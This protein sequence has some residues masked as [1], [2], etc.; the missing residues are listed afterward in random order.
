MNPSLS[1]YSLVDSQLIELIGWVLL[2]SLWQVLLVAVI[3]R[4]S[5][6]CKSAQARYWWGVSCL[7]LI[8][9]LPVATLYFVAQLETEVAAL[10]TTKE[11][12]AP[13]TNSEVDLFQEPRAQAPSRSTNPNA[14]N[15]TPPATIP[16]DRLPAE[17]NP[18]ADHSSVDSASAPNIE[19][20]AVPSAQTSLINWTRRWSPL[21]VLG[22]L[23]GVIVLSFRPIMGWRF[24][25]KLRSTGLSP[26]PNQ[27]TE[28][29][30]RLATQLKVHRSVQV[31]QSAIAQVPM[32]VG[33]FK[34]VILV[35]ASAL[36][37]LTVTE[38][39]SILR[40][41]LAHVRRHDA[42]V[43]FLQT[44][45]ETVLFFHPC[46]WWISRRVRIEREN[47][48][49]DL[50]ASDPAQAI[51]LAKALLRLEEN[52]HQKVGALAASDG[53]LKTRVYRLTG[54]GSPRSSRRNRTGVVA[55]LTTFALV[56]VIF[57][58]F[59]AT[60][61]TNSPESQP[62]SEPVNT[63]DESAARR[64]ELVEFR[65]LEDL[66]RIDTETQRLKFMGDRY[67]VD[68]EWLELIGERFPDLWELDLGECRSLAS[69][70][71]KPLPKLSK[72][73]ALR[74]KFAEKLRPEAAGYISQLQNLEILDISYA[75]RMIGDEA[76][77]SL[78]KLQNLHTLIAMQHANGGIS[79][80]SVSAMQTMGKLRHVY[81]TRQN[82]ITQVP[83][84]QESQFKIYEVGDHPWADFYSR[85]IV[86]VEQ[87]QAGL[88]MEVSIP[89]RQWTRDSVE[90][91][92]LDVEVRVVDQST[93]E[94][95]ELDRVPMIHS[96]T[97]F[98]LDID[99][100]VY[101]Y[102]AYS[103][104][105]TH[106]M[107]P[108]RI[109]IPLDESMWRTQGDPSIQISR[110]NNYQTLRL[111]PGMHTLKVIFK[112]LGETAT[113]T[114]DPLQFEIL[115]ASPTDKDSFIARDYGPTDRRWAV[116]A[117]ATRQFLRTGEQASIKVRVLNRT[118]LDDG[119]VNSRPLAA[120]AIPSSFA[121]IVD[122]I[123]YS[124][125]K[126]YSTWQRVMQPGEWMDTW[127]NLDDAFRS[128]DNQPLDLKPGNHT[129][130]VLYTQPQGSEPVKS[131]PFE[132]EVFDNQLDYERRI[133]DWNYRNS[134]NS[135]RETSKGEWVVIAKGRISG[136]FD[137]FEKAAKQDLDAAHR[138]IFRPGIDDGD[139]NYDLS[140][141]QSDNPTWN[142][143]GSKIGTRF[144]MRIDSS[145]WEHKG[146]TIPTLDGRARITIGDTEGNAQVQTL[147][148][149]S[150]MFQDNLTVTQSQ[151]NELKLEKYSV[152]GRATWWRGA[153]P[154]RKVW[155][156]LKIDGLDIDDRLLAF[157]VPQK[158]TGDILATHPDI[159][160][161]LEEMKKMFEQEEEK[162]EE[163]ADSDGKDWQVFGRVVDEE[164]NPIEGAEVRMATGM[165]T[166]LGGGQTGTND[167][168]TF[169]LDFGE[170]FYATGDSANVQI[171]W[172]F[173]K[174]P[175]FVYE[176]NSLN[177]DLTMAM[178][179]REL[180]DE[181][182]VDFWTSAEAIFAKGQPKEVD[183]VMSRPAEVLAYVVDEEGNKL[184]GFN[185]AVQD[186]NQT[187]EVGYI[188]LSD[189]ERDQYDYA[190]GL[191]TGRDW[192]LAVKG[193]DE[194]ELKHVLN[195]EEPGR[196]E[197]RCH[198]ETRRFEIRK[199]ERDR[200]S[201]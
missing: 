115:P 101:E 5:M 188:D 160:K 6:I 139:V 125:I 186:T 149:R 146:K 183:I 21:L 137:S 113:L 184:E 7:A 66:Q 128:E 140:V 150:M 195:F 107:N 102:M 111:D 169:K 79:G 192:I 179:R 49:D 194:I 58:S 153:D 199:L 38:L 81:F 93:F 11:T 87:Q 17:L 50:A 166:L 180:T 155:C 70:D 95:S 36:T 174:E 196:Y 134:I 2:N 30:R 151:S 64:I 177:V 142:Q 154:G 141:M 99:G 191:K 19:A 59:L 97:S 181:E 92:Q 131:L 14:T 164:G 84:Q 4:V 48:C 123:K 91:P 96:K 152:P 145:N 34:P 105:M 22:W 76:M 135:L 197:I 23:A 172:L 159:T 109:S 132:I 73:K 45:L 77:E 147:A 189:E 8:A 124:S 182:L 47:C 157:V 148:V 15:N 42:L 46:V 133:N 85:T 29:T 104:K 190:M 63:E 24:A 68:H 129:I 116:A 122:G 41:E 118:Q 31:M 100:R 37:N 82:P 12:T 106:L 74:I 28:L 201:D 163:E 119:S 54:F 88:T 170:G 44:V 51:S 9:C 144:P 60:R 80:E 108:F 20:V 86:G 32:V 40:H 89:S 138:F 98:G 110:P 114:S 55:A 10:P 1:F 178:A 193:D 72:L 200:D 27:I 165:G 78:S 3:F 13:E 83:Q 143:L 198:H 43:N 65:T 94:R 127:F 18:L 33:Y 168:G 185:V 67:V 75:S 61:I 39:E 35:P 52:R 175:G 69:D 130:E 158:S 171:A 117:R 53:D 112:G 120:R 90:F 176:S 126:S 162:G 121:L 16:G 56:A 167:D 173:V 62:M 161:Q 25:R 26:A 103:G 71:L 187:S 156:Q 136:T 57:G